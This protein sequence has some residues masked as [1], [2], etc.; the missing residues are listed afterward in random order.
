[1]MTLH[2]MFGLLV[3]LALTSMSM[4]I[5]TGSPHTYYNPIINVHYVYPTGYVDD[6]NYGNAYSSYGN[7]YL[8]GIL[9]L[10]TQ[11]RVV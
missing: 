5:P 9:I 1:M 2:I 3:K 7:L 6:D 4:K 11:A 8:S 10:L